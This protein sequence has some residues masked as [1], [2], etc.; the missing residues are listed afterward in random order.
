MTGAQARPV[1]VEDR[2]QIL[3]VLSRYV[4]VID[5]GAWGEETSVFT[6]D[7]TMGSGADGKGVPIAAIHD[8]YLH[9][10]VPLF[11]HQCTDAVM[12]AE[13]PDVVRVWS[14][15]FTVRAD[16]TVTSGDYLDTFVRSEKAEW[17][18][19]HR[20]ASLGNRPPTDP[21]GESRRV[22]TSAL[23]HERAPAADD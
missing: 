6:V 3:E 20:D 7:A 21:F 14:K 15:F 17:R 9:R 2:E 1:P 8:A 23:W 10:P 11:P 16:G 4:Q 19:S 12:V 18:I 13:E 5:N 22:F